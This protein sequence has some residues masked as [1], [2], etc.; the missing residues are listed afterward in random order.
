MAVPPQ[1]LFTGF[2]FGIYL[3]SVMDY[4]PRKIISNF[5][6]HYL[7]SKMAHWKRSLKKYLIGIDMSE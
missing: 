3:D 5:L 6:I 1:K 7:M 4:R 2:V